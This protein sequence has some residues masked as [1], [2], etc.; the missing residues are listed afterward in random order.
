M[1]RARRPRRTSRRRR[2]VPRR[3]NAAP[4]RA[5]SSRRVI[6]VRRRRN[7]SGMSP[8]AQAGIAAVG[9][10]V[11]PTLVSK[12]QDSLS[13]TVNHETSGMILGLGA[14]AA[15]LFLAKRA[16]IAAGA[17]AA[18]GGGIAGVMIHQKANATGGVTYPQIGGVELPQLGG[19][20]AS[21]YDSIPLDSSSWAY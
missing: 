9:F 8:M 17:L 10:A 1:A 12:L 2:A 20:S 16:P 6:R 14:L 18:Y 13:E 19:Y 4:R 5:R 15:G 7:P 3:T 21:D 11:A